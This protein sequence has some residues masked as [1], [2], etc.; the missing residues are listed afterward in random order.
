MTPERQAR[1]LALL[2]EWGTWLATGLIALGLLLAV[3]GPEGPG[4]RI[5]LG[6]TALFVLLPVFRVILLGVQFLF[7][8]EP[9]WAAVT[10]LVLLIVAAGVIVNL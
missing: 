10:G 3:T 9:F 7:R 2:M 6:G 4:L 1:Q 8:R 5:I